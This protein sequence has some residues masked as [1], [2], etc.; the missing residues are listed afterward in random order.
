MYGRSIFCQPHRP[1][2]LDFFDL[3]LHWLSV[4]LVLKSHDSLFTEIP[5]D[6]FHLGFILCKFHSKFSQ[7]GDKPNFCYVP[8]FKRYQNSCQKFYIKGQLNP[9][10]NHE[11]IFS[12]KMATKNFNDFCP[13]SLLE[14]R[15]EISVIFGWDLGRNNDL[16]NSF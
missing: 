3:C 14:G 11:V 7:S 8:H 16:I 9:E 5:E 1:K 15:A 4:V 6:N 2:C 12:P 10:C 13:G